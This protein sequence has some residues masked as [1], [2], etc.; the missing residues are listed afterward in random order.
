MAPAVRHIAKGLKKCHDVSFK[1]P[2]FN[3]S[4]LLLRIIRLETVQIEFDQACWM[5]FL[6]AFR[7][8]SETLRMQMAFRNDDISAFSPQKEKVLI[9]IRDGPDGQFLVVEMKRGKNLTQGCVLRLPCFC[10][11]GLPLANACRPVHILWPAI[12]PRVPPCDHLFS[13]V[14]AR[15]F[16][17]IFSRRP[18]ETEGEGFGSIQ[19]ARLPPR[20]GPIPKDA[21]ASLGFRGH[22][23]IVELSGFPRLCR[24]R[25]R[26]RTGRAQPVCRGPRL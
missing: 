5:S 10:T 21:W 12:R 14:N 22:G 26:C 2:N 6:F 11:A 16:N 9:G 15:N 3:H 17:R 8:P 24:H 4:R 23:R 18:S 13:A 25:G 19:F 1:L 7:V 20:Y